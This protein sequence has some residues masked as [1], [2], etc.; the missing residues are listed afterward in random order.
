MTV[1]FR[2][3]ALLVMGSF[4]WV[5]VLGNWQDMRCPECG[6]YTS[7]SFRSFEVHP[8]RQD[9]RVVYTGG[10]TYK[11]QSWSREE[12]FTLGER[13][14]DSF[15]LQRD[16]SNGVRFDGVLGQITDVKCLRA[17]GDTWSCQDISGKHIETFKRQRLP[18][19]SD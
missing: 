12:S 9:V 7:S 19:R 17:S 16:F 4:A 18:L 3:L 8:D 15:V 2:F 1:L 11:N 10:R 6:V 14:D 5:A 13:G